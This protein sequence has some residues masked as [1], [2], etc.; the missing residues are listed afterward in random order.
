MHSLA[1]ISAGFM[2]RFWSL[3]AAALRGSDRSGRIF[4]F[5]FHALRDIKK[6]DILAAYIDRSEENAVDLT[7]LMLQCD[8]GKRLWIKTPKGS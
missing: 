8:V 5:G 7:M 3:L 4:I 6:N 1:I 2:V